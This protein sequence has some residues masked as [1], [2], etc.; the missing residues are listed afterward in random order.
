[1][2]TQQAPP[3][4]CAL[5]G[6]TDQ[7]LAIEHLA[8]QELPRAVCA[9]E[10]S[11]VRARIARDAQ[12]VDG[13]TTT[14]RGR[15]ARDEARDET[16]GHSAWRDAAEKHIGHA[17]SQLAGGA[18]AAAQV[19][20]TQAVAYALLAVAEAITLTPATDLVGVLD[21]GLDNLRGQLAASDYTPEMREDRT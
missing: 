14:E 3:G 5:C 20:A 7:P 19:R 16:T 1:M 11:C 17:D 2:T 4:A 10:A 12:L 9:N 18:S 15:R 13:S 6:R 8:G 21:A